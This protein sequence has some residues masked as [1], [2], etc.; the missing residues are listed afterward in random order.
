MA[1][2]ISRPRITKVDLARPKRQPG[3]LLGSG[4]ESLQQLTADESK[5][6]PTALSLYLSEWNPSGVRRPVISSDSFFPPSA[7]R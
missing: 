5:P 1:Q 4:E 2:L 6:S 7:S 3:K